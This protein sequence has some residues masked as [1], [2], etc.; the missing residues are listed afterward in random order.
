MPAPSISEA[1]RSSG[2]A[3]EGIARSA[4]IDPHAEHEAGKWTQALGKGT[5]LSKRSYVLQVGD[6][7]VGLGPLTADFHYGVGVA[8]AKGWI[9]TNPQFDG[10]TGVIGYLPAK[11]TA[12]VVASTFAPKGDISVQYGAAVFDRIAET[13]SPANAPNLTVCPRGC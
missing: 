7:N 11:K 9:F 5:L 2:V 13:V 12:V 6:Q 4:S 1:R 8:Y 10:Y 3:D